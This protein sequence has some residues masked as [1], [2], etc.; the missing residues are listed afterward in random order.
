MTLPEA[1]VLRAPFFQFIELRFMVIV[2]TES[3][4]ID[5]VRR[6]GIRRPH[7]AALACLRRMVIIAYGI[8][9]GKHNYTRCY[10]MAKFIVCSASLRR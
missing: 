2:Q 4:V 5:S 1:T 10:A 6:C 9:P 7:W 8:T 3:A